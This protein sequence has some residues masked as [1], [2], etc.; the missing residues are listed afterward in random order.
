MKC[1]ILGESEERFFW[2]ENNLLE[3]KE[4][5]TTFND[6]KEAENWIEEQQREWKEESGFNKEED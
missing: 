3:H 5:K 1:I 6:V 4:S 2:N